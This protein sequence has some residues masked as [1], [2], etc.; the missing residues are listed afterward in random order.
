MDRVSGR[1]VVF[2]VCRALGRLWIA[3]VVL[4]LRRCALRLCVAISR[5]V[6]VRRD[7]RAL[8][9]SALLAVSLLLISLLGITGLLVLLHALLW[10]VVRLLIRLLIG[11][12][13]LALLNTRLRISAVMS[14][15]TL[16]PPAGG[17][18]RH[19]AGTGIV[20]IVLIGALL[21][22]QRDDVEGGGVDDHDGLLLAV[23]PRV[24]GFQAK[25]ADHVHL[26]L[27]TYGPELGFLDVLVGEDVDRDVYGRGLR[28]TVL[29]SVRLRALDGDVDRAAAAVRERVVRD[30]VLI[31]ATTGMDDAFPLPFV[32]DG[33]SG[34]P[35]G[36]LLVVT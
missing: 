4:A 9:H 6:V 15:I 33:L 23:L 10:T 5:R 2:I 36:P 24:V 1:H 26:C 31:V 20:L 27:G 35:F 28:R 3:A 22:R 34:S 8:G 29:V 7:T 25:L 14:G 30:V 21:L 12:L 16:G 18:L 11:L 19:A 17:G 13:P 32:D